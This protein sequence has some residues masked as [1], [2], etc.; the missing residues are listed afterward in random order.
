MSPRRETAGGLLQA[1][2]CHAF[3]SVCEMQIEPHSSDLLELVA[4]ERRAFAAKVRI[5]RA[6][7]GW[8]QSDLGQHVGLTQR[9]IHKLEQG[10]TEPRRSTVH[11]I[12]QVWAHEGLE[13]DELPDG[14]FRATVRAPLLDRPASADRPRRAAHRHSAYRA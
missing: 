2:I 10:E 3:K 1:D 13:F 4:V 6:V 14:G 8:S 7:L 11:A 12:E 5:G 9:A